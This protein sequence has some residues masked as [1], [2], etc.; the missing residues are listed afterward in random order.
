MISEAELRRQAARWQVDPMVANLDHSL[1][2]FLA[3]FFSV[4]EAAVR[5]RFKGGTCLRKCYF[6]DYRFSEDLDFT[7]AAFVAPDALMAWVESAKHWAVEHDGPDLAA[8]PARLEVVEDEYG[9]E[10]YQVR[11]YFHGPL[12]WGGAPQAIRLDV[13]RDERLLLPAV[14]RHLIHP[15]SDADLLES[16]E[17]PCYALAEIL[18]EKLR[19]VGAQRR[20]AVSRDL[21]DVHCLIQAGISVVETVPLLP[22][23]FAARGVA[24]ERLDV[25]HLLSRHAEFRADWERRL[26]YLVPVRQGVAFESAW[27]STVEAIHLAQSAL[28]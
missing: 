1:G 15:Y 18:A 25:D 21:Y 4:G 6:A 23:K 26:H 20:F 3:A 7:A 2:W 17:P 22:A 28:R 24:M 8:A 19:A 11:V 16:V 27:Q 5:L 13:T 9:S 14:L 12:R 10:S